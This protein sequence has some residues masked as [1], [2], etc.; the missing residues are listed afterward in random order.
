M[1]GFVVVAC[2]AKVFNAPV[3]APVP[4]PVTAPAAVEPITCAVWGLAS[5]TALVY[6]DC[7]AE[8]TRPAVAAFAI[9]SAL[10]PLAAVLTAEAAVETIAF[11]TA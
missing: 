3:T 8:P 4:P 7:A 6:A 1:V 9:S 11:E 10:P 5:V 2:P